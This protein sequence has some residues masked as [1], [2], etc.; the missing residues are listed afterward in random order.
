[1]RMVPSDPPRLAVLAKRVALALASIDHL[2]R[3]L[4]MHDKVHTAI[5]GMRK[6]DLV[7]ELRESGLGGLLGKGGG[8]RALEEGV[9]H[10]EFLRV[11]SRKGA[12]FLDEVL[13][14]RQRIRGLLVDLAG[15]NFAQH[16]GMG[17]LSGCEVGEEAGA[18]AGHGDVLID[19]KPFEPGNTGVYQPCRWRSPA[20]ESEVG[21]PSLENGHQEAVR[22]VED[23]DAE[24]GEV[25]ERAHEVVETGEDDHDEGDGA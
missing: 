10:L 7:A 9:L 2:L 5:L 24:D 11:L 3:I 4:G 12:D 17:S 15:R 21:V 25:W 16:K 18:A 6:P 19:G 23:R 22:E 8:N 1:M 14:H 13:V 20:V